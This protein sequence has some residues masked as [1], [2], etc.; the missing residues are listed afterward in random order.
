MA[1][2][3]NFNGNITETM[4]SDSPEFLTALCCLYPALVKI[5]HRFPKRPI[6]LRFVVDE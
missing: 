5:L 6:L 3:R 1:S 4:Y 2:I